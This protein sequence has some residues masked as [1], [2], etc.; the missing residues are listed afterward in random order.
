MIMMALGDG[1]QH[2]PRP[3]LFALSQ[4]LNVIVYDRAARRLEDPRGRSAHAKAIDYA[5][6]QTVACARGFES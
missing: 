2:Q 3:R 1:G 5:A 4:E 6:W